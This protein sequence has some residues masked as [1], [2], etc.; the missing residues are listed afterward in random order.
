MDLFWFSNKL[1]GNFGR[2]EHF[3]THYK[4][5]RSEKKLS[6][7]TKC[8]VLRKFD[9]K[10]G[11]LKKKTDSDRCDVFIEY[12]VV[13]IPLQFIFSFFYFYA[14]QVFCIDVYWKRNKGN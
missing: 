11:H 4:I 7:G 2:W 6:V 3:T 14:D 13:L 10:G 12:L 1:G 8:S 5:H 9:A